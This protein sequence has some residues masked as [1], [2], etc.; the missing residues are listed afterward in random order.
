MNTQ[1][2][3]LP[4]EKLQEIEAIKQV[5]V[6]F[7]DPDKIILYGSYAKGKYVEHVYIKD[8]IRHFYISDYDL[9]IIAE[10]FTVKPYELADELEKRIGSRPDVN[11]FMYKS[12][13]F[14]EKLKNGH[15]FYVPVYNEGVLLY[16]AKQTELV[17]PGPID[18]NQI[19]ANS[20]E[21]FDFWID[22]AERFYK[23][24]L[25]EFDDVVANKSRS[26]L[27]VWFSFQSIE[28]IYSALLLIFMG[29]KPK[30]HNL[31]RYRRSVQ[32]ISTEL[33]NIFPDVKDSYERNLF[34]LLNRAYIGAKYKIDYEA[35]ERD[36]QELLKR[37]EKMITVAKEVCMERIESYK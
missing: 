17:T 18:I 29:E 20:L 27:A 4:E 37:V 6:D 3:K 8:G 25:I 1:L 28:S 11:F 35:P 16:D 14:N 33:N 26:N 30:H 34:D 15:H 5:I 10:N 13:H 9:V 19:R 12:A 7:V 23:H 22:H 2:P 21:Y 24:A 31:I 36:V 32:S